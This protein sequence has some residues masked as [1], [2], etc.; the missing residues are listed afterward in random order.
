MISIK[1][2]QNDSFHINKYIKKIKNQEILYNSFI[3]YKRQSHNNKLRKKRAGNLISGIIYLRKLTSELY[4]KERLKY[5]KLA[6][7]YRTTPF[8]GSF[9]LASKF[10][11][12]A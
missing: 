11:A 3:Y 4:K 2:R 12:V 9:S 7:S 1:V 6:Q 10:A 5:S 8:H